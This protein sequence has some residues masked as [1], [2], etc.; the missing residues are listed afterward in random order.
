MVWCAI[1][2]APGDAAE[3]QGGAGEPQQAES[4]VESAPYAYESGGRRD[5]FVSVL[6]Q[7]HACGRGASH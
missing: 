6:G 3:R 1:G 5:P 7:D 2:T 4:A